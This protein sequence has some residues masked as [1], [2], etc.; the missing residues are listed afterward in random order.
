MLKFDA[1]YYLNKYPDVAAAVA[2]GKTTAEAHFNNFGQAEG[3]IPNA[4]FN[5]TEYVQL[6]KDLAGQGT[7]FNA[8]SHY[9]NFGVNEGRIPSA[10]F[11]NFDAAK[12][13]AANSDLSAAGLRTDAQALD[14][15]L[16]YGIKEGRVAYNKDGSVLT[17][18]NVNSSTSLTAD[19]TV[20]TDVATAN[21]FNAGLGYTPGG[22]DRVNALQD[23]DILTGTG[24]NPTLNATLGNANDNGDTI[25]TPKLVNVQTVNVDFTGSGGTAVRALDLQD[26]TGLKAVNINR[27]TQASNEAR[28]ENIKQVVDTMSIARTNAN[29]A[30]TVEFSFGNGTLAGAN[31]G[32]LNLSDVQVGTVNVGQ[33]SSGVAASGVFGGSYET[34]TINSTGAANSIGTINLPMDTNT[35]DSVK[36]TGDKNLTLA[37]SSTII[38][39]EAEANSNKV[40]A[41]VFSGGIA[42]AQ[43][44]VATVD[45]SGLAASFALNIGNSILTSGKADTSGVTQDVT[46]TGSN[47]A[48]TFYLNDTVQP[49]DTINGGDG[50]DKLVVFS[51]GNVSASGVG[52]ISKVETIDVQIS[53]QN[54]D[55]A[56]LDF[57][58]IADATVIG[59]RNITANLKAS[60]GTAR[61]A[62]D[63][64]D[65][66][67]VNLTNLSV[68][69]AS[70]LNIYHSTTG[71]NAIADTTLNATLANASGNSDT[72][73]VSINEGINT[74]PR[75]NFTF[76]TSATPVENLTI[77]D[78]DS[79][80]NAVAL[81]NV[82]TLSNTLTVGTTAGAGVAGTFINFDTAARQTPLNASVNA[83]GQVEG[84]DQRGGYRLDVNGSANDYA[85]GTLGTIASP[86][87]AVSVTGGFT[88]NARYNTLDNG[89]TAAS[90]V[91][92][93]ALNVDASAEK[94]DVIIRLGDV[95]RDNGV[96]SQSIKGGAGN[97]TF[98]FDAQGVKNSGYTSGDTVAAGTGL[99]TLV[100]DGNTTAL[101][102]DTTAGV[103]GNVS[104]QKSE[105]D[106]T[107]GVDVLRLAG[108]Q[109]YTNGTAT[110]IGSGS[111]NTIA[112]GILAS[113]VSAGGYYVEI[114]NEFVKQTDAG[115]NLKIISNDGDL[116]TNLESDL[117]LNLRELS[118]TSNV[119]FIGAN[120]LTAA[121]ATTANALNRV[122][123][124]DNS[125]NGANYLDGGDTA[126][127][128]AGTATTRVSSGNNN[129]LEVF[130]TADVSINDLAN[131]K[132]FGRIEG[133]NDVA[134]SQTL[135]LV[136]NDTVMDQ[137][138]DA[139]TA[140]RAT[141][142]GNV[143][144][145]IERLVVV[146][147]N[148]SNIAGAVEN[149]NIDATAVSNKFGLDLVLD[150]NTVNTVYGTAGADKVVLKGN[151]TGNL[152]NPTAQALTEQAVDK[153]ASL[154]LFAGQ[155]SGGVTYR[156]VNKLTG[157]ALTE[158]IAANNVAYKG[159]DGV[160]GYN[161]T[162]NTVDDVLLSYK[163]NIFKL[164]ADNATDQGDVIET[165][166]G[167]D[168]TGATLSNYISLVAHSTVRVTA[169]QFNQLKEV[170]FVGTG[171]H[172][173][174]IVDAVAGDKAVDLS[175][176]VTGE[177]VVD[178]SGNV[179]STTNV[180]SA[181]NV[182]LGTTLGAASTVVQPT[183]A[184]VGSTTTPTA[185]NINTTTGATTVTTN[186][187]LTGITNG[188]STT[189][190]TTPTNPTTGTTVAVSA[191]NTTAY[192]ASATNVTFN[193][194]SGNYTYNINGF[195][196]GDK[197]A[198]ATGQA[199]SITNNSG[200][201]G[202]IDITGTA[203]GQLV[204][205]HL[206][207]VSAAQDGAVFSVDSFNTAFGSG[208]LA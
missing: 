102:S 17:L 116:N 80:S 199:L 189:G 72:I 169:A 161:T 88:A 144:A 206:T 79:E 154:T 196:S 34:L 127:D 7:G 186:T 146:A 194:A 93:T 156:D 125:A 187:G 110:I 103:T 175:K 51:G 5:P 16:T 188:T 22:N 60:T 180:A 191:A 184:T 168:L 109:G 53:G 160:V 195:G 20:N 70:G 181:V 158:A 68:T 71:N 83:A 6:Y 87:T 173:I 150:R 23:E 13:L 129:V 105:W 200:S 52:T 50:A 29:N 170:K 73:A 10:Q 122:Q 35:N 57:S 113:N 3:R 203:N 31:T 76:T 118:Q 96:S 84:Y 165:F 48:D 47:Q 19:L 27:V 133:T 153:H 115:N 1:S 193:V 152:T 131:T 63:D 120:S 99:D 30:G 38:N 138:V 112:N 32:T 12:Y 59:V 182:I 26:T 49:G 145:N 185:P 62:G 58:K 137:L 24:T 36:I 207:G 198:F 201:D 64:A 172:G 177:T 117:I 121:N 178:A 179:L 67:Q 176:I 98:I 89:N 114:D 101:K 111:A 135:K 126:I 4:Y 91:R 139:G 9:V 45:A 106:N 132:N 119:N 123:V 100:I 46:I 92:V 66:Q 33:N 190:T 43:G 54:G 171:S 44:R 192:D 174:Q 140:A 2:A 77:A 141:A 55:A 42:Q 155:T 202:V 124:E 85:T 65:N 107:T 128:E 90:E 15:Y 208:S 167:V 148:N 151:F 147:N 162:T 204:T 164:S 205:I 39:S 143:P 14:H 61:I 69:Q 25:I 78:A 197:L 136:L 108:N 75:F 183:V 157:T 163:G 104:V 159:V 130:N 95:T 82:G 56:S 142:V 166:G 94:S 86:D 81:A 149:V 97:D 8:W 18:T 21:V 37:S 41:T 74:D 28:I 40:E 11:A 134:V